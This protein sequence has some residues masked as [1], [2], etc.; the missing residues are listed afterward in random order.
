MFRKLEIKPV[1]K[2]GQELDSEKT[3]LC[4]HS[5]ILLDEISEILFQGIIDNHHRL[6]EEGSLLRTSKIEDVSESSYISKSD[7]A[8]F[9]G[10]S[11]THAGT[12]YEQRKPVFTANLTDGL[13]AGQRIDST[14]LRGEGDVHHSRLDHM[15]R[16][17][18]GIVE[19]D[20][21]AD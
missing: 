7:I 18:L 3:S 20:S 13:Q 19:L 6:S 10:K 1:L 5:S 17:V 12:I 15:L 9:R 21:L 14:D 16:T 4:K 11:I 2:K 8:S